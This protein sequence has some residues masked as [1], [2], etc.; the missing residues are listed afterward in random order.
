MSDRLR[1]RSAQRHFVF[2]SVCCALNA[3]SFCD[4]EFRDLDENEKQKEQKFHPSLILIMMGWN[5][6][7]ESQTNEITLKTL[8]AMKKFTHYV[9]TITQSNFL[10]PPSSPRP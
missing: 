6:W 8:P 9:I 10:P 2:K 7:R 4:D 1:E 5:L 3:L